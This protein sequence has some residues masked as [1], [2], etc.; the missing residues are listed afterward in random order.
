MLSF[1]FNG[2][3]CNIFHQGQSNFHPKKKFTLH[4]SLWLG[5]HLMNT[6]ILSTNYGKRKRSRYKIQFLWTQQTLYF[7]QS[8]CKMKHGWL[9]MAYIALR[10]LPPYLIQKINLSQYYNFLEYNVSSSKIQL[11]IQSPSIQR[12]LYDSLWILNSGW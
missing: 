3:S 2:W 1:K 10:I 7:L 4:S 9:S 6:E 5:H 11:S 12:I 8:G